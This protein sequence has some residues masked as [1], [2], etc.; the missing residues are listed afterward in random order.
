MSHLGYRTARIIGGIGILGI[1]WLLD[2]FGVPMGMVSDPENIEATALYLLSSGTFVC[3]GTAD[4]TATVQGFLDKFEAFN[5][6]EMGT[7]LSL[8]QIG[9]TIIPKSK[10]LMSPPRLPS[11]SSSRPGL[12]TY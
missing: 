11:A 10:S 2:R 9:T 8:R 1:A 6:S 12:R 4:V 7:P 5:Q 3:E